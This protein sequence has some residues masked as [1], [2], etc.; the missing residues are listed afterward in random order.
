MTDCDVCDMLKGFSKGRHEEPL[1]KKKKKAS[2]VTSY[3]LSYPTDFSLHFIGTQEHQSSATGG[4]NRGK[5]RGD[6]GGAEGGSHALY[7][8]LAFCTPQGPGKEA[9][10]GRTAKVCSEQKT[11]QDKEVQSK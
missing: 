7:P 11:D 1:K 2:Q 10:A 3:L 6:T 8:S 5:D 4:N 9:G